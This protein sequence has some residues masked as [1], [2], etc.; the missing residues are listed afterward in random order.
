MDSAWSLEDF[1]ARIHFRSL[2]TNRKHPLAPQEYLDIIFEDG[3]HHFFN[4]LVIR[5]SGNRVGV[6]MRDGSDFDAPSFLTFMDWTLGSIG[7]VSI[8]LTAIG[9]S[10]A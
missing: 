2:S 3:T 6:F 1:C 7:E 10:D 8:S 5:V 4:S 9:C